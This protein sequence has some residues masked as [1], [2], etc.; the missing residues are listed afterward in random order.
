M[1]YNGSCNL[2]MIK[3][4]DYKLV[5]DFVASIYTSDIFNFGERSFYPQILKC[6]SSVN[7]RSFDHAEINCDDKTFF[8]TSLGASINSIARGLKLPRETTRRK[9]DELVKLNWIVKFKSKIY[10]GQIWRTENLKHNEFIFR[11]IN[12]LSK[13]S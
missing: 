1:T 11:Q 8:E 2:I 5:E 12:K 9:I 6:I 13:N 4:K 7:L 3:T 10:V